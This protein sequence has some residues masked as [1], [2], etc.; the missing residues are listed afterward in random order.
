[1]AW[2]VARGPQ[3]YG[4][5]KPL[6]HAVIGTGGQGTGHIKGFL[7]TEGVAVVALCDV[8]PERRAKVEAGW[9]GGNFDAK[10]YTNF[11]ELLADPNIDSVSI[12]T[13]D[14]WHTPVALH[15]L[16]AGKHV[17]VEK[18]CSHNIHEAFE[19]DR[20]ARETGLCVQHGTQHRSG[21]GPKEAVKMMQEGVIGKVR[22]AK[23]IN[24]QLRG[25]IGREPDTET[26]EGVD[27][28]MWLGPAPKRSFSKNRWHYNWH[29]N[30]DYGTGDTG[31]DGVHQLDVM[32]WGMGVEIPNRVTS[33]GAQLFYDDD[34]ETPDTQTAIFEYDDVHLMYEMRLWTNY[35]IEG[36]D[37]GVVFY[38]D[39]G[40]IEIGR[41][42]SFIT[43]IGEEKK[44][45]GNSH[46]FATNVKNFAECAKSGTP[47]NLNA[48]IREG[49][50]ST[51]LCH[52]A[53]IGTRVGRPLQLEKDGKQA[54]GDDA[55]NALFTRIYREGYELPNV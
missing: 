21:A 39:K 8:D 46:D 49:A 13:P 15:A 35:K 45:I 23:A 22:M 54:L 28:D 27:Y 11:H 6:R 26:P 52:Y 36:H 48:P 1:V 20:V 51:L 44:Q 3:A 25:P 50:L 5:D 9:P 10:Y 33:V 19:L 7:N 29:W 34:H 53:N 40:I 37:N 30:W 31:N 14:H 55:A 43:L 41:P 47:D 16:K 4:Q 17:Y 12:A 24:H 38:G 18:P 32:R 42:G 2:S